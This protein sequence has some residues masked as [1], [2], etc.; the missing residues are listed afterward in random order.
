MQEQDQELREYELAFL[1]REEAE[2]KDVATRAAQ[3]GRVTNPGLVKKLSLA[4]PIKKVTSGYFGF[5]RLEA[6]PEA[7][8]RLEKDFEIW[9]QILRF[10]VIRLYGEKAEGAPEGGEKPKRGSRSAPRTEA[11]PGGSLTNEALEKKIEEILQ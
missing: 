7:I 4:Y 5:L 6:M 9:Q 10:L 8:V 11:A 2:V 3:Y 1:V